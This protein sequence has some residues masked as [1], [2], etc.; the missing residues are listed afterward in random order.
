[1]NVYEILGDNIFTGL[2]CSRALS[3]ES[4]SEEE[5]EEEASSS[6]KLAILIWVLKETVWIAAQADASSSPALIQNTHFIHFIAR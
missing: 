4:G 2:S 5:E 3:D 6:G 1:M